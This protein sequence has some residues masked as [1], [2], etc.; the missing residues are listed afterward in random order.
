MVGPVIGNT[1]VA[2][3]FRALQKFELRRRVKPVLEALTNITVAAETF[4]R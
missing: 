3:D 4:D 2:D 1:F